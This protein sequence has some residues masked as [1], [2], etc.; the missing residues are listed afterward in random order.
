[1]NRI[2]IE[3]KNSYLKNSIL[4]AILEEI[5]LLSL[6]LP[7]WH[8]KSKVENSFMIGIQRPKIA[9]YLGNYKMWLFKHC[10]NVWKQ[11]SV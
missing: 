9:Q 7:S 3:N 5:G 11:G 10:L 8:K 4:C 1:M 6:V 2:V